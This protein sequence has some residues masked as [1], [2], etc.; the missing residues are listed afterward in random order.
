MLLDGRVERWDVWDCGVERW[1]EPGDAGPLAVEPYDAQVAERHA[2]HEVRGMRRDELLSGELED[3]R[4]QALDRLWV[5]VRLRFFE[6]EDGCAL[7][8]V[9][10]SE[11]VLN[12]GL[13][14]EDDGEAL[15]SLSVVRER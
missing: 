15:D 14:E 11:E 5:Q 9:E 4:A 8:V 3:G 1:R 7:G 12:E 6:L 13:E 10:L 2:L